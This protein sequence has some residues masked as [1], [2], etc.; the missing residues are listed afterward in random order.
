MLCFNSLKDSIIIRNYFKF[1]LDRRNSINHHYFIYFNSLD[2]II[3]QIINQHLKDL[4]FVSNIQNYLKKYIFYIL[5][6]L[7]KLLIKL[8]INI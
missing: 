8:L 4:N 6:P 5:I 1:E 3:N 2:Q 7:S